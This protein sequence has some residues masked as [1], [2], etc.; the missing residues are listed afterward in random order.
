VEVFGS[1]GMASTENRT[2]SSATV[3]D[4]R[5]VHSERPLAFFAERYAEAYRAELEAFVRSVAKAVEPPVTGKDGRA[6]VVAA[7]AC[8]E[9]LKKGRPVRLTGR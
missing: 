2:S 4:R 5:G 9:S 3:S 7:L 8:V 1:L 6:A